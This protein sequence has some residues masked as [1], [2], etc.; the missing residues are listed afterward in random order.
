MR[1]KGHSLLHEG[2]YW[3]GLT[4]VAGG[5]AP[6][7]CSCG[8]ASEGLPSAAARKRWHREHKAK[9]ESMERTGKDL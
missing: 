7:R 9:I 6:G 2:R 8:Q 5:M 3:D 1:V 4:F